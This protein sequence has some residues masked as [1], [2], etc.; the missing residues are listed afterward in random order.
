M[1]PNFFRRIKDLPLQTSL[2]ITSWH[3]IIPQ[4][5]GP[6][7]PAAVLRIVPQSMSDFW[8][9]TPKWKVV[10]VILVSV[11]A[12]LLLFVF[13]RVINRRKIDNRIGFL[14]RRLL[15][16]IA[17]LVLV[18]SLQDFIQNQI[19]VSGAFST[20]VVVMA[21]IL[22]HAAAIWFLWLVVLAFFESIVQARNIPE[23]SFNAH[24]WRLGARTTGIVAGV[25]IIGH[26]S[27]GAGAAAL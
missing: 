3:R 14:L 17:I 21:T 7:I 1:A 2:P 22:I 8:L 27:A 9:G 13:H 12:V 4:F 15:T 11:L 20:V 26:G 24:L 23:D 5:T 18:W 10:A 6:M 16:P 25:V 19:S